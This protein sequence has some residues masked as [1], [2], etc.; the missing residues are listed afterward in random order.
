MATHFIY[1]VT[2]NFILTKAIFFFM[3]EETCF[4]ILDMLVG[5]FKNHRLLTIQGDILCFTV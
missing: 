1:H 3:K 2:F 4:S 5:F